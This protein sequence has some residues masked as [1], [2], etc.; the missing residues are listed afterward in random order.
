MQSIKTLILLLLTTSTLMLTGCEANSPEDDQAM[1]M[2]DLE[3]M[4]GTQSLAENTVYTLNGQKMTFT[5]A[6]MYLS[7]IVLIQEDDTEV[8]FAGES[9]TAPAKNDA[10][11]TVT[12]TTNDRIVLAK[13]DAGEQAYEL[14]EVPAGTYKGVR[15]KIGIS[16]LT[17]KM[18]PTQVP[19]TH[20]LTKQTDRNNH[21]SWN[22]GYI[23]L[24][25]DGYLDLDGDGVVEETEES[26][27]DVH[28]G[29]GNFA[30]VIQL[31][32][33]FSLSGG[34]MQNLHITVDYAKM[35]A[36]V[37]LSDPDQRRCH[38]MDN[39]PVAQKVAADLSSAFMLH[40]IHDANHSN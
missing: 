5:S 17:N 32:E 14:G 3:P 35:L 15:F 18:D 38:T 28:I 21:W 23:F 31:D 19:A 25:M 6:R 33:T 2:L 40:G 16:G 39:L 10:D 34:A 26:L 4:V 8:T 24:R 20:A 12:H 22:S 36:N 27:W 11:E 1:I 30:Q 13:H 29:T 7:E 9:I 37:D